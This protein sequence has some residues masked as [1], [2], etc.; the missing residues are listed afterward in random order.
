MINLNDLLQ[1]KFGWLPAT[2]I[3][4]LLFNECPKED[5]AILY[6]LSTILVQDSVSRRFFPHLHG[7]QYGNF[8]FSVDVGMAGFQITKEFNGCCVGIVFAAL[9]YFLSSEQNI[10]PED[11]RPFNGSWLQ[12]YLTKIQLGDNYNISRNDLLLHLNPDPD[13]V[14]KMRAWCLPG[15]KTYRRVR[16][17]VRDRH[18]WP[19]ILLPTPDDPQQDMHMMLAVGCSHSYQHDQALIHV[20]DPNLPGKEAVLRVVDD[21][22]LEHELNCFGEYDPNLTV[23]KGKWAAY[24]LDDAYRF[25]EPI[26]HDFP[27]VDI[28]G[29]VLPHWSPAPDR[30]GC[31]QGSKLDGSDFSNN[32]NLNGIDFYGSSAAGMILKKG[33]AVNSSFS[34]CN[35]NQADLSQADLKR[36]SFVN[37]EGGG[38]DF[39]G[40]T[41]DDT[42]FEGFQ[43]LDVDFSLTT[44]HKTLFH[45]VNLPGANFT[46]ADIEEM[47]IKPISF[48]S[49]D[50]NYPVLINSIWKHANLSADQTEDKSNTFHSVDFTSA[51]FTSAKVMN[52]NFINCKMIDTIFRDT[53]FSDVSFFNCD[54]SGTDFT[55]A[56]LILVDFK[57]MTVAD[58]HSCIWDGA[59]L[60]SVTANDPAVQAL[61]DAL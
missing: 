34:F 46:Q 17:L 5:K 28:S 51:D 33:S 52:S 8:E 24:Y 21:E 22:I 19:I 26:Q 60:A 11:V 6:R 36:S 13:K 50:Q 29:Q 59:S 38:C 31:Y 7:F 12:R 61:L 42:D 9:N 25:C 53:T 55:G 18:P 1:E 56:T 45:R 58:F 49:F 57:D 20:Y 2:S 14:K 15:G 35:L 27:P 48:W 43:G 10:P 23:G 39:S 54:Y 16:E 37:S 4:D 44:L 47:K 41:L 32:K 30:N 40:S 3:N